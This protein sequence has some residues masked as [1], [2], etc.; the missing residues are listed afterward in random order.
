MIGREYFIQKKKSIVAV[1][2]LLIVGTVSY[3]TFGISDIDTMNT[4]KNNNADLTLFKDIQLKAAYTP[5][6]TIKI[7]ALAKNNIL[8]KYKSSNGNNLPE[9]NSIVIGSD[10]ARMMMEEKLFNK[11]GDEL[12]DFFGID[13]KVEGIL[14]STGTFAD[15]FHFLSSEQY[16]KLKGDSNVLRIEFKDANTPKLFYLYDK[17]NPSP[18]KIELSDGNINLFYKHILGKQSYYPIIIGAKEAKMM[19]EEK[20]FTKTG[21]TIN[22]FFGKDVIVVGIIKETNTSLDM[23]HIVEKNFFEKPI[24]GVLV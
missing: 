20:L 3:F 4:S 22:D 21:D 11:P 13:T 9:S 15:D 23:M 19:Q 24:T 16:N 1:L 8:K 2:V 18:V 5:D 12:K 17:D 7:F 6:G 10:E 14:Y